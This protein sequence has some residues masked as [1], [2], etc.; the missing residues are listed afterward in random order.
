[1]G[2]QRSRG[3]KGKKG[4]RRPPL[5]IVVEWG[6]RSAG[7]ANMSVAGDTGAQREKQIRRHRRL[8]TKGEKDGGA[9]RWAPVFSGSRV[10]GAEWCSGWAGGVLAGV[11]GCAR[12]NGPRAGQQVG[13]A[14]RLVCVVKQ[15][16]PGGLDC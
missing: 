2:G 5:R 11:L 16:G 7:A 1:M 6:R 9:D 14:H 3:E 8:G 10:K 4:A 13:L 15:K 12:A